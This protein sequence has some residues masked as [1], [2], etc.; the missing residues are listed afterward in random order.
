MVLLKI[1]D[2]IFCNGRKY[3]KVQNGTK[4]QFFKKLKSQ[5]CPEN[6]VTENK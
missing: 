4:L 5:T 2:T 6:G 1:N 3:D